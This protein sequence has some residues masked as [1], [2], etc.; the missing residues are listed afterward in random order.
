MRIRLN[1]SNKKRQGDEIC[2]IMNVS[3]SL[4]S[5]GAKEDREATWSNVLALVK[6]ELNYR[7]KERAEKMAH[8]L[9]KTLAIKIKKSAASKN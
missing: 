9:P 6:K 7:R 8:H 1:P 4:E 5:S 3:T 2:E